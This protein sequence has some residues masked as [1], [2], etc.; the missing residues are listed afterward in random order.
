MFAT[1]DKHGCSM[2]YVLLMEH[3]GDLH[4][5]DWH[6]HEAAIF[7]TPTT[8]NDLGWYGGYITGMCKPHVITQRRV[9]G[10][11]GNRGEPE[12]TQLKL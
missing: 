4:N 12:T 9:G 2:E 10:G 1:S 5:I 7:Q 11:M 3:Y 8:V 6:V